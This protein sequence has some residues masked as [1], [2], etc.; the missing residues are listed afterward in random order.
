MKRFAIAIALCASLSACNQAQVNTASTRAVISADGGYEAASKA[1]AEAV[2]LHKLDKATFKSLDNRAY[3]A[4]VAFRVARIGGNAVDLATATT[5]LAVAV[6]A[7][8]TAVKG[9]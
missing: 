6:A 2:A 5:G 3:A 9:N 4:L 7:L 8:K 1:G